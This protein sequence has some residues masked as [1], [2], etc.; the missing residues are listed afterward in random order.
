M[1]RTRQAALAVAFAVLL[2]M[3]PLAPFIGPAL[4][5]PSAA[6]AESGDEVFVVDGTGDNVQSRNVADGSVNWDKTYSGTTQIDTTHDESTLVVAQDDG[7]LSGLDPSDGSQLWTTSFSSGI[8][9]VETSPQDDAVFIAIGSNVTRVDATD[10]TETW[11]KEVV[12]SG[13][14]NDVSVSGD[15]STVYAAD[16]GNNEI[17]SLNADTGSQNWI[18]TS[19]FGENV[20]SIDVSPD[21]E[22]VVAGSVATSVKAYDASDGSEVWSRSHPTESIQS[23]KV[24]PDSESA[25]Y[26]FNNG[27]IHGV[28]LSN[29]D[30]LWSASGNTD[31]DGVDVSPNGETLYA[32][33]DALQSFNTEDGSEQWSVSTSGILDID[34]GPAAAASGNSIT[35]QVTTQDGQPVPNATVQTLS[36]NETDLSERFP[37]PD[38]L[39]AEAQDLQSEL[40]TP[41]PDRLRNDEELLSDARLGIADDANGPS[42]TP[43]DLDSNYVAVHRPEDW[44]N[45]VVAE[46]GFSNFAGYALNYDGG[47]PT[48]DIG[49][50]ISLSN[51]PV[52]RFEEGPAPAV[53]SVWDPTDESLIE[54]GIDAD[55]HGATVQDASIQ[56]TKVDARNSSIS[57]RTLDTEPVASSGP[58]GK[59]HYAAGTT[60]S[61]GIYWVTPEGGGVGYYVV[62]GDPVADMSA[63]IENQRE[64]LTERAQWIRDQIENNEISREAVVTNATGHFTLDGANVHSATMQAYKGPVD[65][66]IQQFGDID[67]ASDL[68]NLS[69]QDLAV[70]FNESTYN[71]SFYVPSAPK[72]AQPG[73]DVTLRVTESVAP[74]FPNQMDVEEAWDWLQSYLQNHSYEEAL[75]VIEQRLENL[76]D[77]ELAQAYLD[78]HDMLSEN[79]VLEDRAE[80]LLEENQNVTSTLED[81]RDRAEGGAENL[82]NTD[83][84]DLRDAIQEMQQALEEQQPQIP[85]EGDG[86]E[87][88]NETLTASRIFET[89]LTSDG[90]MAVVQ[91]ANGS[92]VQLTP[93]SE[94][95]SVSESDSGLGVIPGVDDATQVSI[96]DYPVGDSPAVS[97]RWQAVSSEGASEATDSA[98]NP[99]FSG[100]IPSLDAID[101]S[102][103]APG[104]NEPVQL[105]VQP[106][107]TAPFGQ[108]EAI[109]VIGPNGNA[110]DT[111]TTS[112]GVQE[113][114]TAGAGTHDVEVTFSDTGG[115][116]FTTAFPLQ[117][118]TVDRSMEPGIRVRESYLGTYALT[119]DGLE[120]GSID[121]ASDGSEV[122]L[123]GKVDADDVPGTVHVYTHGLSLSDDS[124]ISLSLLRAEN[125]RQLG[126][127]ARVTWHGPSIGTEGLAWR[128]AA[129]EAQ[130]LPEDD[131]SLGWLNASST[132]TR[133]TTVTDDTGSVTIRTIANPSYWEEIEHWVDRQAQKIP[134][135][136]F[137][138]S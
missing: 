19:G 56:V 93:D 118:A 125:E 130:A 69:Q 47:S 45:D 8:S 107:D 112:D 124:T 3:A 138:G 73:E 65:D 61:E 6:D 35:G 104:P 116:N 28:S 100:T 79:Q 128:R 101:V 113:F 97:V 59:Q 18:V 22:I 60:L 23:V 7:T 41:F 117:A 44:G 70:F 127:A 83:V 105:D 52:F 27:G 15:G 108:V 109:D 136:P 16:G 95:M 126:Q 38:E 122:S 114:T 135:I 24:G 32:G 11:S 129:G 115:Q 133:V 92:S 74:S 63:S 76:G 40:E 81:L 53:L 43:S 82:T 98:R 62:V 9:A 90:V 67:S 4:I 89:D 29:G 49:A 51:P 106:A 86:S 17:A 68:T 121:R 120:G 30:L 123:A 21:N 50:G 64:Q 110:L 2:A 34:A 36:L 58:L 71:G 119:G 91:F 10:G 14:L 75:G 20:N 12:S 57:S 33:S 84:A 94:Y 87:I 37:D 1:T 72:T 99:A 5:Q 26:G 39:E 131:G 77:G 78:M 55:L 102:S 42:V 25:Y 96:E 134:D 48:F 137:L 31:V 54:D 13:G 88:V 80:S 132:Q 103:L 85:S 46:L 111:R 66:I